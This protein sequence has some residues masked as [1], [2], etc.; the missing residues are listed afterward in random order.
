MKRLGKPIRQGD[1]LLQR[2]DSIPENARPL[3]E[4]ADY[5]VLALGEVTGHRHLL[6]GK[7]ICSFTTLDSNEIE[8]LLVGGGG[9]KLLHEKP[10]GSQADHDPHALEPGYYESLVQVEHQP[11]QAPRVV[12]D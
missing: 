5:I 3:T 7:A 1:V 2:V 9:G 11:E 8:F 4:N 6:R 12:A 10:D